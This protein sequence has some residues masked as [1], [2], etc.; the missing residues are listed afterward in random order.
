MINLVRI[1]LV[2]TSLFLERTILPL[3]LRETLLLLP[4]FGCFNNVVLVF[5]AIEPAVI[6]FFNFK[7]NGDWIVFTDCLVDLDIDLAVDSIFN[8]VLIGDKHNFDLKL[9][10]AFRFIDIDDLLRSFMNLV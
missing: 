2:L 1:I 9:P 7:F 10:D 5:V 6:V 4:F 8:S 3:L